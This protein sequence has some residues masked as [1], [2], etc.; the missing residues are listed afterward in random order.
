MYVDPFI[1]GMITGWAAGWAFLIGLVWV[2]TAK[3]R[4]K[5]RRL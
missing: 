1:A 3:Q 2:T 5:D 4:N